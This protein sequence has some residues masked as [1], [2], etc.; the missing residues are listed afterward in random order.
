MSTLDTIVA[1]AEDSLLPGINYSLNNKRGASFVHQRVLTTFFPTTSGVYSPTTQRGL[2]FMLSDQG[3]GFLDLASVRVSMRIRNTDGTNPLLLTGGHSACLF[4]RLQTRLRGQL[5]DDILM[6][7]RLVGMLQKF[8]T[9]VHNYN[10]GVAMTGTDDDGQSNVLIAPVS[11][12]TSNFI[13][14]GLAL[15]GPGEEWIAPNSSRTVV[16]DLPG[17]SLTNS[18]FLLWLQ[19]FPLELSLEVVSSAT[20]ACAPGPWITPAGTNQALSTTFEI[21]DC[22]LKADLLILDSGIVESVS[23]ALAAGTPLN[24]PL[25]CWSQAM[26]PISATGGSFSQNITRSYS[27]LKA[28]YITFR[29]TKSK[30]AESGIWTQS[31]QFTCHHGGSA[32]DLHTAPMYNFNRDSY[33]M[34]VAIGSTLYPSNPIRSCAEQYM[35]LVKAVGAL[36]EAVGVSIGPNYRS[37]AHIAG[38]DLEKVSGATPAGGKA[39]FTG[40]STKNSGEIRIIYENIQA[41]ADMAVGTADANKYSYYPREMY[42]CLYYDATVQLRKSGVLYAD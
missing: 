35:Q 12:P 41:D 14:H 34:Q 37:N 21:S 3:N 4:T 13:R 27:R 17:C 16:F 7:N 10:Q 18:H 33:R 28:A 29:P 2:K 30:T 6:Y 31:N 23:K 22:E 8:N 42:V 19:Q 39:S 20:D 9:P 32:M 38:I 26:Y 25:R 11:G 36:Q 40:I 5:V 24:M 1:S 15:N